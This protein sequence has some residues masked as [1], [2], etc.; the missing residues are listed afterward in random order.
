MESQKTFR[1]LVAVL[2]IKFTFDPDYESE[3]CLMTRPL[4]IECLIMTKGFLRTLVSVSKEM[5]FIA[6]RECFVSFVLHF[7]D[8]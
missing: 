5:D 4:N 1:R 3:V 8:I 7:M 6:L 2:V